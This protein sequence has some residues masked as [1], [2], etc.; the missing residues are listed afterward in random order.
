MLAQAPAQNPMSAFP[1]QPVGS[2]VVACLLIFVL[3]HS[4]NSECSENLKTL[5]KHSKVGGN[6]N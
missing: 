1:S 6:Q 2:A 4:L 3:F 5:F